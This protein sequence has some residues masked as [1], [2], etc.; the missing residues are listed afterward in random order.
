M[1]NSPDDLESFPP[2]I[3]LGGAIGRPASVACKQGQHDLCT[4]DTCQC[5]HHER[6]WYDRPFDEW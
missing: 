4:D 6:F 5:R 3:E 1:S 2:A